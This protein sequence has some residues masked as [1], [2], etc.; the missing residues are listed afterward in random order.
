M[1]RPIVALAAACIIAALPAVAARDATLQVSSDGALQLPLAAGQVARDFAE[2]SEGGGTWSALSPDPGVH[3]TPDGLQVGPAP[4]AAG[5][6]REVHWLPGQVILLW[7]APAAGDT[8]RIWRLGVRLP[9][10]YAATL[11]NPATD[12]VSAGS[13]ASLDLRA[14]RSR[15]RAEM[16]GG[17]RWQLAAGAAPELSYTQTT[18]PQ[19]PLGAVLRLT[20]G[21]AAQQDRRW[22]G[23]LQLQDWLDGSLALSAAMSR[24]GLYY[25]GEAVAVDVRADSLTTPARAQ[26]ARVRVLGF[27]GGVLEQAEA[28]LGNRVQAQ[29]R[30]PLRTDDPGMYRVEVTCGELRRVLTYGVVTRPRSEIRPAD[31]VFG[32][33]A[34]VAGRCSTALAEQLGLR[35]LRLWEPSTN[36]PV[37]WARVEPAHGAFSWESTTLPEVRPEGPEPVGVL[38]GP[39]PDWVGQDPAQWLP[40]DLEAWRGY[41]SATVSRFGRSVKYWE[42]MDEPWRV[43]GGDAPAYVRALKVACEAVRAADP[44]SRVI[45]TGC[46]SGLPGWSEAVFAAGGLQHLDVVSARLCPPGNAADLLDADEFVREFIG[47]LRQTMRRYGAEKPI[48]ATTCGLLPVTRF[49]EL[50]TPETTAPDVGLATDMAARLSVVHA[51]EGVRL[52]HNQLPI[53]GSPLCDERG[54]AQPAAVAVATCA[55]AVDGARFVRCIAKGILR[56]YVFRR[57]ADGVIAVWGVGLEGKQSEMTLRL[58]NCEVRDVLGAQVSLPVTDGG[59]RLPITPSPLYITCPANRLDEAVRALREAP[60][61]GLPD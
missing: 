21:P 26:V 7:R 47:E 23:A 35:W 38:G 27:R 15:L 17:G 36:G 4:G 12:W 24:Q 52:F 11:P 39:L 60:P 13:L 9:K 55:G 51:A 59:V 37:A 44:A 43:F 34:D 16:A 33:H 25:P 56:A 50:G 61:P 58:R 18:G 3:A 29:V 48:W 20:F 8:A 30:L 41:V 46:P 22:E 6:S 31:S 40:R 14:G 45:G 10:G 57:D 5:L 49:G 28:R 19:Q 2:V 53:A 54:V 1:R 42:V 32:G